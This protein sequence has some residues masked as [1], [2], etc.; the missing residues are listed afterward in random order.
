M[1]LFHEFHKKYL[2][3]AFLPEETAWEGYLLFLR[4][5]VRDGG[6]ANC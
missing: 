2:R 3:V 6:D 1:S 5:T 4:L